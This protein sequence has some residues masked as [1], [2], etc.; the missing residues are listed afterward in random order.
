MSLEC[1]WKEIDVWWLASDERKNIFVA[2]K[3]RVRQLRY[4]IVKREIGLVSRFQATK[5]SQLF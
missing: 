1:V 5:M 3:D 4:I 2:I